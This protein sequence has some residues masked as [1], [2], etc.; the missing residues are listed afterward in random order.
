MDF[1]VIWTNEFKEQQTLE[2]LDA[3]VN[4]KKEAKSNTC[5]ITVPLD[6]YLYNGEL[7]IKDNDVFS[8]Y[9]SNDSID[10][11]QLDNIPINETIKH[12]KLKNIEIDETNRLLKLVG[13]DLTYQLLSKVYPC[14]EENIKVKDL[15]NNII[16]VSAISDGLTQNNA[17]VVIQ[18]VR[19]NGAEFPDIGYV[20]AYKNSYDII[21][22]L[23]MT[24]YTGDDRTYQFY[25]DSLGVFHWE[26][27]SSD[28]VS[29]FNNNNVLSLKVSKSET[30]RVNFV[31][32]ECGSDKNGSPIIDG[33]LRPDSSTIEGATKY[34]PMLDISE[35]TKEAIKST[36][37]TISNDDFILLCKEKAIA[38]AKVLINKT[39]GGLY[40]TNLSLAGGKY[41]VAELHSVIGYSYSKNSR[42]ESVLHKFNKNGWLV[43]LIL[44][45]DKK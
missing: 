24:N 23:S 45:E 36:Y 41:N 12:F 27:P 30:T 17:E 6:S 39:N 26:Y 3:R 18:S 1:V 42:V 2:V 16:Q 8:F 33:Y 13:L 34:Q 14:S 43:S 32:Y 35:E 37:A 7:T 15:I 38:R 20:S 21:A 19:S 25:I 29:E 22:E 31:I 11:Q 5:E 28:V 40:Q 44:V 10:R 9:A 4:I